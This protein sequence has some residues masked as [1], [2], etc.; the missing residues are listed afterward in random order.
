MLVNNDFQNTVSSYD[1]IQ[2]GNSGVRIV[3]IYL[4]FSYCTCIYII[5]VNIM[6]VINPYVTM[7]NIRLHKNN[8]LIIEPMGNVNNLLIRT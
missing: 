4:L 8:C 6:S 7:F 2:R 3:I 1:I 5:Q